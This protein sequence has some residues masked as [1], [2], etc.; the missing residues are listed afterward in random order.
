M[1]T[2]KTD[3]LIDNM[4]VDALDFIQAN[5]LKSDIIRP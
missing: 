2:I 4:D 3:G 1:Y 5:A